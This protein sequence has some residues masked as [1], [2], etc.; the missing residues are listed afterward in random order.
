LHVLVGAVRPEFRAEVYVPAAHDPVLTRPC[1]AGGALALRTVDGCAVP[2]CRRSVH[3][4]GLCTPHD[5]TWCKRGKPEQ[6]PFIREV[7]PSRA[8][9]T[10]CLLAGCA[11]LAV[12]RGR[13]CD[14]HRARWRHQRV[15]NRELDV[16]AYV[17]RLA[18]ARRDR[19][20]R[21]DP[22]G[23]ERTLRLELRFALQR[24]H[25]ARGGRLTPRVYHAVVAWA[26]DADVSSL[27]DGRP[28]VGALGR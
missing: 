4:C 12:P 11:F 20:P 6:E 27:L 5:M 2:G 13:L 26:R 28:L 8:A 7:G 24:R 17:A 14:A 15:R 16:E 10:G 21:F 9:R 22:R 23:L 19:T 3:A 25:D 1:H 18:R